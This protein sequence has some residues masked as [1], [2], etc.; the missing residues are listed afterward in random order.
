MKVTF[1]N[2]SVPIAKTYEASPGGMIYTPYP[3]IYEF[4]SITKTISTIEE[5][6]TE[7]N[8][9]AKKHGCLLKGHLN[10]VL[11]SESR[12]GS[13]NP[14]DPTQWICLDIDGV[15]QYQNVDALLT[16][17][18]LADID[19][20]VQWSSSM[21]IEN[22]LGLR[23]HVFMLLSEPTSPT[24]LKN[25]LRG[26]NLNTKALAAQLKLTK[27][28][29]ALRWPLDITTCQNDKLIYIAPP[30]L[31]NI[32][33]PYP[34]NRITLE[35]RKHRVLSLDI[36][37]IPSLAQVQEKTEKATNELRVAQGLKKRTQKTKFEGTVEYQI[38][39]NQASISGQ[40][41]ERGFVYFNLNGGD[42]W[43]YYHPEDN[44]RYIFNFKGEPTYR[45]QDLL[46]EYWA[47]LNRT[48]GPTLK[49]K[50]KTYLAFCEADTGNYF[51]AII[52]S[53]AGTLE[54][55]PA[56]SEKQLSDFLIEH[57]QPPLA[58][59]VPFVRTI[60]DPH[61]RLVYDDTSKTLNIYV[62]PTMLSAPGKW[63]NINR[64]I[65]HVL[66]YD[67][68]TVKHFY[69]WLAA[70]T[71]NLNNHMTAWVL[72]GTQGTGKG[73]LFN[74]ILTPIFG[75]E[76]V[77]GKRM[78]EL[79]SEFTG[80]FENKIIIFIDEMQKG[81]SLYHSKVEAKLKNLITEPVISIRGMYREA[82][83]VANFSNMIFASN[84][85]SPVTVRANDRRYNVGVYQPV[86]IKDVMSDTELDAI[87]DEV[88]AFF[89]YLLNF[90]FDLNKART[91]LDN[92]ARTQMIHIN[93]ASIDAVSE[94]LLKGDLE[95]F[96]EQLPAETPGNPLEAQKYF[97]FRD[98]VTELVTNLPAALS[99]EELHKLYEWCI[100]DMPASPNKFTSLLK[101]HRV[102][103]ETVWRNNRSVRGVKTKWLTQS[104]QIAKM[105]TDLPNLP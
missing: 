71:Q 87:K 89:D 65:E 30:I 37:K 11:V 66:G 28:Q 69:N 50:G 60:F 78:E 14:D 94:A 54:R 46:P 53:T 72:H 104:S 33:D 56:K 102:Y 35:K 83:M 98:V 101:H 6:H 5:F 95:F 18:D 44:P 27:T 10:R 23:C 67:P 47:R 42:S 17:L 31:K 92:A 61:N 93:T 48:S 29:N 74:Q 25:W 45:T 40:K 64:L 59:S 4:T 62:P 21:G 63:P 52:D 32:I 79:E 16:D 13:T 85:S 2:A 90:K 22:K 77:V 36:N 55:Y 58:D 86:P 75:Q 99:R 82:R 51:K 38:N 26:L 68:P 97:R 20:I 1:L 84:D 73:I 81:Q 49:Q 88:P 12:A 80:F 7:I 105:L 76:N 8:N 43:G 57:G 70:V 24:L 19:Y 103:M 15:D 34:K 96:W 100:G 41:T 9:H 91:V 3:N 39:P